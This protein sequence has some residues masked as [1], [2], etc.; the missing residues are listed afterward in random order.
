MAWANYQKTY[1]SDPKSLAIPRLRL[2]HAIAI[3]TAMAIAIAIAAAIAIG[4]AVAIDIAMFMS[5]N[6][7]DNTYICVYI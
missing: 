4:T 5:A 2:A 1:Q 3:A 7:S 6:V